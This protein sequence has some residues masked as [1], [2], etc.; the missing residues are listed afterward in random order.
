MQNMQRQSSPNLR[1]ETLPEKG[2]IGNLE[3]KKLVRSPGTTAGT[4]VQTNIMPAAAIAISA[5]RTASPHLIQTRSS[6]T[7]PLHS[8]HSVSM[9]GHH[10]DGPLHPSVSAALSANAP[11]FNSIQELCFD[12]ASL[13]ISESASKLSV[14]EHDGDCNSSTS[15]HSSGPPL[16]VRNC[17][18]CTGGLLY[19]G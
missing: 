10:A 11:D 9:G 18:P 2:F 17:L 13:G 5:P 15:E 12:A 19:G 7:P 3:Q 8:A 14:V 4:D 6:A 1:A 16:E